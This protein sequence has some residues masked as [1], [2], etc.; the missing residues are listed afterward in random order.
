ME[1]AL[2]ILLKDVGRDVLWPQFTALAVIGV[3]LSARSIIRL[4]RQ[5]YHAADSH[6]ER[7]EVWKERLGWAKMRMDQQTLVTA[8]PNGDSC[9]N[10]SKV[11]CQPCKK[12]LPAPCWSGWAI[13]T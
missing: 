6:D 7:K 12:T 11:E 13:V 4:R 1:I 2:G 3:V 5:L 10:A 9:S 8:A